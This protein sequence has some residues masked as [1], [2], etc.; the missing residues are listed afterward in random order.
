[1]SLEIIIHSQSNLYHYNDVIEAAIA[2]SSQ[3]INDQKKK[4]CFVYMSLNESKKWMKF[5]VYNYF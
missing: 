5:I 3:F 2:S 4:I 1:M